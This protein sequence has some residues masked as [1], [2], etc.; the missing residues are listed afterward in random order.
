MKNIK[1]YISLLGIFALP[2]FKIFCST[3]TIIIFPPPLILKFSEKSFIY[4]YFLYIFLCSRFNC[5]TVCWCSAFT[6]GT[7]LG[8][9]IHLGVDTFLG[10]DISLLDQLLLA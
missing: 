9:G 4:M 8:Q 3:I 1:H 7:P 2:T 5:T 10:R 6:W